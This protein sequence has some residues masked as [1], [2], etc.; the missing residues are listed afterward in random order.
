MLLGVVG[1]LLGQQPTNY[2]ITFDKGNVNWQWV[3][4][5]NYRYFWRG[6]QI[7]L[8]ESFQ[9]NLYRGL[10]TTKNW[11]DLNDFS[12]SLNRPVN[13]GLRWGLGI[14]SRILSD[15][16][17]RLRFNKHTVFQQ[18]QWQ[19]TRGVTLTPRAG[20]SWEESFGFRDNGGYGGGELVVQ[21]VTIGGY[22]TS[23]RWQ[24]NYRSFPE[25]KNRDVLLRTTFYRQFSP[26][27]SDSFSVVY[28]N[29]LN[30]YYLTA[31]GALETVT[32]Q[33]QGIRNVLNYSLTPY[34]QFQI[35]SRV[36][37]RHLSITNPFNQNERREVHIL[38]RA[39]YHWQWK[40][41]YWLFTFHTA[42]KVQDN[43]GVETDINSLQTGMGVE[44]RWQFAK[45]WN[46]TSRFRYTKYEFNTP[47]TVVNHDDRDEQRFIWNVALI[48]Q[49]SSYLTLSLSGYAYWF[50]QIYIHRTRSA[51][52]NWNR[53]YRIRA[54][55]QHRPVTGM[56][57]IVKVEILANYTVYDFDEILPTFR[58]YV[59]RKLIIADSLNWEWKSPL[60]F[61]LYYR[62]EKEDNGTFFKQLFAQQVSQEVVRHFVSAVLAYRTP[63]G[64]HISI[65]ANLYQRNEWRFQPARQQTRAFLSLSPLIQLRYERN[66][67]IYVLLEY[68]PTRVT[69]FGVLTQQFSNAR[70]ILRYQF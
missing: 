29:A 53:I 33:E 10:T 55:I 51:N 62:F 11:K 4:K 60:G 32:L 30:R 45:Q 67:A 48:W 56:D 64:I 2:E 12:F 66:G 36:Q 15:Q 61:Q 38:T 35:I 63:P 40:R 6:W 43:T 23:A 34:Q 5:F 58:S 22:E 41:G 44:N 47:D 16:T 28:S 46:L 54:L 7:Y 26:Q 52:N 27:A 50:H 8:R 69:D 14:T 1:C 37:R 20:W 42:Q 39:Y 18:I 19:V 25:R 9:S 68:A 13:H 59:F 49:Y 70:I 65:G 24:G 57:H 21:G 17:T 31:A 3:G